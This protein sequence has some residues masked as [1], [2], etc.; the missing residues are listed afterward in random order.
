MVTQVVIGRHVIKQV[1][2]FVL[3]YM[4]LFFHVMIRHIPEVAQSY[5]SELGHILQYKPSNLEVYAIKVAAFVYRVNVL[6]LTPRSV[7]CTTSQ[8][9]F[10]SKDDN[11]VL[12]C[13]II[14]RLLILCDHADKTV[15]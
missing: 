2:G 8:F 5:S 10:I 6:S 1:I 14:Y 13:S 7:T 12:K 11:T 9:R 4:H 15:T 3:R